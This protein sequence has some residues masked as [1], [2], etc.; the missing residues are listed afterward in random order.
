MTREAVISKRFNVDLNR[1]KALSHY[2]E[3]RESADLG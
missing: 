1:S 2:S 3:L